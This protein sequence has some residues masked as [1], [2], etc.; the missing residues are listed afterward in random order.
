MMEKMQ[1]GCSLTLY[2]SRLVSYGSSSVHKVVRQLA[3]KIVNQLVSKI[4]SQLVSKVGRQ[5]VR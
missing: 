5:L 4:G 1:L 3:S 2:L